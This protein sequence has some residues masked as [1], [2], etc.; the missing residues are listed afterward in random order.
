MKVVDDTTQRPQPS[1]KAWRETLPGKNY[2]QQKLFSLLLHAHTVRI[3]VVQQTQGI[4][5][6]YR[7]EKS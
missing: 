7:P 1:H 5:K 3:L 4:A 2:M 6:M